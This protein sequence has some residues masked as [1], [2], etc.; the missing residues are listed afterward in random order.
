MGNAKADVGAIVTVA[1]V[2]LLFDRFVALVEERHK[3][4]GWYTRKSA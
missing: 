1:D 4:H 2:R 3:D